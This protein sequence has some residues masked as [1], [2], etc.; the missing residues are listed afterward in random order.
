MHALAYMKN[1]S[2]LS[3]FWH[4]VGYLSRVRERTASSRVQAVPNVNNPTSH[5]VH[6]ITSVFFVHYGKIYIIPTINSGS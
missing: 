6:V 4:S 5:M 1:R 2:C 3:Y